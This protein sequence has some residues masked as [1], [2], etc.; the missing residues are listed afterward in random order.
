MEWQSIPALPVGH[1][2]GRGVP[3]GAKSRRIRRSTENALSGFTTGADAERGKRIADAL[4]RAF[5]ATG[6]PAPDC[7]VRSGD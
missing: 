5:T 7:L 2:T 1:A 3:S 4:A 6:A